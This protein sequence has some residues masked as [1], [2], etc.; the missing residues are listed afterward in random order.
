MRAAASLPLSIP[1]LLA[2]ATG[3]AAHDWNGLAR[4]SRGN[5]FVVDAEDGHVW[6]VAPDGSVTTFVTSEAGAALEHPHH[7]AIDERD[8]LWLGSG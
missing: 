1:L 8:R 5:L 6:K 4:D 7:L 3:A 2:L